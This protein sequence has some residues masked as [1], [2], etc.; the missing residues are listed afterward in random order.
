MGSGL[1]EAFGI[2]MPI[3]IAG[4]FTLAWK[5][6]LRYPW[7]FFALGS[8]VI[9]LAWTLLYYMYM[10]PAQPYAVAPDVHEVDVAAAAQHAPSTWQARADWLWD[11]RVT[12][13]VFAH[14]YPLL[15]AL[16]RGMG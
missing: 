2:F 14:S 1:Y 16:R 11:N 15:R 7:L 3:Y 4:A 8:L 6:S 5:R 10:S 13:A 12:I 9:A